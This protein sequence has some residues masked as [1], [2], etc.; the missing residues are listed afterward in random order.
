MKKHWKKFIAMMLLSW[1]VGAGTVTI[2]LSEYAA[3]DFFIHDLIP[4]FLILAIFGFLFC[5]L[6]M[7]ALLFLKEKLKSRLALTINPLISIVSVAAPVALYTGL[8][9]FVYNNL[10]VAEFVLL[11]SA[12]FAA[13]FAFGLAFLWFYRWRKWLPTL[14]YIF[15]ICAAMWVIPN[16]I[17]HINEALLSDKANGAV[18]RA[19]QMS[20]PRSAHTATLLKNGR[21][22]LVGGMVSVLGQELPT[23]SAEI[24]DPQ[25]N[26]FEPAGKML[27]P[28]A[29]HTATLL[30]N[31]DVLITGG[32]DEKQPVSSAELYRAASGNFAAV[33]SMQVSRERHSATLLKNGTVLITGGTIAQP[34]DQAEIYEP[35]SQAFRIIARM[36]ARRAAQTSTLLT[37]GR[38]LIAGGAESPVSI[39][40]SVEIFDP[41]T[42]SFQPDG[43]MQ[44]SRYKHSAV[45][46]PDGKVFL[47]GG[48]D[49]RDWSG[50]RNSVEVYDPAKHASQIVGNMNRARFKIPNSVVLLSGEKIIVGGA[51]RRVEIFDK[52]TGSFLVSSGSL[53]DEWF[54]ATATPLPDGRV[55]IAGGYNNS[56]IPTT[57]TWLYQPQAL[58]AQILPE[59]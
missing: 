50:R 1:L 8:R 55:F 43:Q 15:L 53:E 41:G 48:A 35:Q 45:L 59:Y 34:S 54:Y 24:F 6:S 31:G 18:A 7:T 13:G 11:T 58:T 30:D 33:G 22:L 42:E 57:Q 5:V 4:F 32:V 2:Y 37:D 47:L 25:T 38:V 29:G 9:A 12:F 49:E 56:L 16:S 14:T 10:P 36:N 51:G 23:A 39:L 26:T 28:R 52:A 44:A 3:E 17:P 19:A 21:V 40:P 20:E 46:M 27:V